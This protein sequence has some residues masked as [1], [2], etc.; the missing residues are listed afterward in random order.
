MSTGLRSGQVAEAD[1]VN[2]QT[3]RPYERR[4]L[5]AAPERSN[6]CHRLYGQDAVVAQRVIKAAPRPGFR[7]GLRPSSPRSTRRSPT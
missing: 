2:I 4:G 7:T 1:G 5:P 3:L 6:G